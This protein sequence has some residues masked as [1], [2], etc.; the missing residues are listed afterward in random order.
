VDHVD[1]SNGY[2]GIA[3]EFIAS[4]GNGCGVGI[5]VEQIRRWA[6]TMPPGATVLELGSGP[7]YPTTAAL[8]AEGLN[9]YAIDASP[10]FVETFRSRFPDTPIACEAVEDSTLFHRTFDGVLA[11]GLIFLLPADEQRRLIERVANVLTPGG[12]FLFTAEANAFIWMDAMTERE[13]RSLGA[14]EYQRLLRDSGLTE[15]REYQDEGENY[16]FDA[17]KR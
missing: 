16:Y 11:W 4:R 5:G 7:G 14:E 10:T 6:R 15:V 1:R 17:V 3:A 13:S 12:R 2:E 8:I 9:V